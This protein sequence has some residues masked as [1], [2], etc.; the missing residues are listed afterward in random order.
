[1]KDVLYTLLLQHGS[2][3]IDGETAQ[4]VAVARSSGVASID[5]VALCPVDADGHPLT[6]ATD[7]IVSLIKHD[8]GPEVLARLEALTSP[9]LHPLFA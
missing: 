7:Q 4:A 1:M 9:K 6:I 8:P 2:Y 5:I 3:C